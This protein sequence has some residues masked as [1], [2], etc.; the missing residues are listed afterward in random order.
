M[1][2]AH[3]IAI[4]LALIVMGANAWGGY[5]GGLMQM[6]VKI[7]FTDLL[8]QTTKTEPVCL[9]TRQIKTTEVSVFVLFF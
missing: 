2:A 9:K 1:T 8:S 5:N 7:M 3:Y 6:P 4:L